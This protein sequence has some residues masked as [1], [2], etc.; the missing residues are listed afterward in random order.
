MMMTEIYQTPEIHYAAAP[1]NRPVWLCFV[2][3]YVSKVLLLVSGRYIIYDSITTLS[4]FIIRHKIWSH[5]STRRWMKRLESGARRLNLRNTNVCRY[6]TIGRWF[7]R[8]SAHGCENSNNRY[9]T[10]ALWWIC[11]WKEMRTQQNEMRNP[12]KWCACRVSSVEA[13][14]E[15]TVDIL[16]CLPL[17][18]RSRPGI[19]K[20]GVHCSHNDWHV[21]TFECV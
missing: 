17:S 11:E 4:Q 10:Y 21:W 7:S 5:C 18:M 1:A 15:T 9:P 2:R 13:R 19:C 16:L 12:V 20:L 8:C 14:N 6:R 3:R